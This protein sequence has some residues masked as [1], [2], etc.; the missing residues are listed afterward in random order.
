MIRALMLSIE[1]LSDRRVAMILIRVTGLTVLMFAALGIGLWYALDALFAYFG[2]HGDS[3]FAALAALALLALS[4]VLLF[5]AVA[6]AITWIFADDIID[7]VEARHY[8]QHAGLGTRP[9]MA[10]GAAMALRSVTRLVG[11]N[12]LALPVYIMLL[13]TGIGTALAFLAVNSLLL[14]RDLE[15]MLIAR[16][17]KAHGSISALPRLAL[18]LIGTAAMLIPLVNLVVPVMATAMAVHLVH[19]R[20]KGV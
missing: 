7:A 18:G 10:S 15:D 6:V 12:L 14:G 20:S 11:Y 8:P 13:V 16:H 19:G 5:R 4:G 17:G 2:W 3:G 1:S 9:G